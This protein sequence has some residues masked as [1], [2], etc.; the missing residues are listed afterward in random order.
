[1]KYK[2]ALIRFS[3][4][5]N[6]VYG[7]CFGCFFVFFTVL[8]FSCNKTS[9]KFKLSNTSIDSLK[10][11]Y[12]AKPLKTI[13]FCDSIILNAKSYSEYDQG[14]SYFYKGNAYNILN[15]YNESYSNLDKALSLFKSVND[16]EYEIR[17]LVALANINIRL[18]KHAV[19]SEQIHDALNL[20]SKENDYLLLGQVYSTQS[21][22]AYTNNDYTKALQSL[23]QAIDVQQKLKDDFA[24]SSTYNNMA[25]LYKSIGKYKEALTYN[26]KSFAISKAN[27]DIDGMASSYTNIGRLYVN[28]SEYDKAIAYYNKSVKLYQTTTIKNSIPYKNLF[29]VYVLKSQ[30]KKAHENI[31]KALNIELTLNNAFT[32]KGIYNDIHNNA[33]RLNNIEESI[34]YKFKL[35]SMVNLIEK[36]ERIERIKMLEGQ[37]KLL[38]NKFDLSIAQS[39]AK[40]TRIVILILVILVVVII[41]LSLLWFKNIKLIHQQN[42]DQLELKVLRSQMNPHFI[43]NALSAIQNTVIKG[44]PIKSASYLARF[45]KLIRQNFEFT[46]KERVS[47]KEDLEALTNYIETQ[48]IRFKNKF[49]YQ[50]TIGDSLPLEDILIPPM[51]LQPFIENAIEHGFK[52]LSRKGFLQIC[53][54]QSKLNVLAI[55]IID[56]GKGYQPSKNEKPHAITITK[57]RLRLLNKGD[58]D[59]LVIQNLGN[60][61]G[62]KVSFTVSY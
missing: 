47:L 11:W 21:Y 29:E 12:I 9:S 17:N 55:E 50:F 51:L 24:L 37:S 52:G 28:Q 33:L 43:F 23:S 62:T 54:K 34:Q 5:I 26:N 49:E 18:K 59:N 19:A 3:Y 48:C 25:I 16:T 41:L 13:L 6:K 8:N 15:N 27:D 40:T 2:Q 22:L 10:R 56:N 4:S 7:F 61:I 39:E 14:L 60:N 58:Q 31:Y 46:S 35:D 57:R 32:L 45:A 36:N 1:M 53:V 30:F 38:K 20:A 44:E 42:K